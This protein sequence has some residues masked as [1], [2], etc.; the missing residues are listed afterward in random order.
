[1]LFIFPGLSGSAVAEH[2][3]GPQAA[4]E[5]LAPEGAYE[6]S[7]S[8]FRT[9]EG[10]GTLFLAGSGDR[11][12]IELNRPALPGDRI[13]VAPQGRLE[14]E[15]SD[16]SVLRLG[17]ETEVSLEGLARSP[18]SED[19]ASRLRLRQGDLQWVIFEDSLGDEPSQVT[20]ANATVYLHAAGSYRISTEGGDWTWIVVREGYGEVVT[21]RGSVILRAGEE[22]EVRGRDYP[23]TQ[24]AGAG[25]LD[26]LERWGRRLEAEGRLADQELGSELRYA[27][28]PLE[29][30]GEWVYVEGDRAWRPYGEPGW[31]PYVAGR[32]VRTPR[33]LTWV[34]SEPWGWVPYHYGS[35]DYAPAFGWVW[36]PGL[37][38]SVASVYWYW[39]PDYVAWIPSGRYNRYYRGHFGWDL[40]YSYGVFGYA[41]GRW[42]AFDD[43]IFCPTARLGYRN[44][45][46]YF[47]EGRTLRREVGWRE[48]PRGIITTDTRPLEPAT[49][50]NFDEVERRLVA[51]RE[52]QLS[53]GERRAELPDVTS[54][55]ER[56]GDLAPDLRKAL[57]KARKPVGPDLRKADSGPD[58]RP[59]KVTLPG[60]P[61]E[62]TPTLEGKSSKPRP[63]LTA[64]RRDKEEALTGISSPG[65]DRP[66][67]IGRD[68]PQEAVRDRPQIVV[69]RDRADR[70]S[71][72]RIPA[73]TEER[74]Q[75][76]RR[77]SAGEI[78]R[79]VS[80]SP[81]RYDRGRVQQP[82]R[83]ER[84]P[85]KE[86]APSA[87]PVLR[88]RPAADPRPAPEA[89][90]RPE[91]RPEPPARSTLRSKPEKSRPSPPPEVRSETKPRP[92]AAPSKSEESRS[93]ASASREAASKAKAESKSKGSSQ[94]RRKN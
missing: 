58:S 6:G 93:K 69:P 48:V 70:P 5:T 29:Q 76:D 66:Q 84:K 19:R 38:F 89:R 25:D 63:E 78:E 62:P 77:P 54:Y 57:E 87:R 75:D 33:G 9:V 7:Y 49:W 12:Q 88:S 17:A 74:K 42:D 65:R 1:M 44:Q 39:G 20:T 10:E 11:E 56:R 83:D 79:P 46:T 71:S 53:G 16:W 85:V 61:F 73:A 82:V 64:P 2:S 28:A 4:A 86:A 80:S 36:F 35:W 30:H 60:R 41:G 23:R 22:A 47:R 34:S 15:L 3:D 67:V 24:V 59:P 52:R 55:L 68:R 92:S 14:V 8:Y 31:R 18:D 94:K 51:T 43:W 50:K 26:F 32:W 40:G 21:D 90:P 91:A 37:R 81:E 45:R 72:V 13:W 27:A